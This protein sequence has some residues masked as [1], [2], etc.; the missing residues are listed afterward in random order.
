MLVRAIMSSPVLTTEQNTQVG[1]ALELMKSNHV[2]HLPVVTSTGALVGLVSESDLLKIYPRKQLSS[3][4][5]NLLS[6]TPVKSVMDSTPHTIGPEETLE[7]AAQIMQECKVVCLP[8]VE[9]S[10]V[11]GMI[12]DNDVLRS[13]IGVMG[14]GQ[15]GLRLSIRFRRQK[16]FLVN[17]IQL[18]DNNNAMID[19]MVTF[20]QELVLK[21]QVEQPNKLREALEAN[22]YHLLHYSEITSLVACA[23]PAKLNVDRD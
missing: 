3:Y 23:I 2:R 19:K 22:G 5:I 14:I 1:Q 15:P 13:F 6:R 18:L 8:V 17:L 11:K 21:L 16:G 12:C 20:P 4:E 7:Q 9:N 10:K